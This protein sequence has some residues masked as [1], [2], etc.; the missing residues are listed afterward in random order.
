[1]AIDAIDEVQSLKDD[2]SKEIQPLKEDIAEIKQNV[3]E[4]NKAVNDLAVVVAGNYVKRDEFEDAL[5]KIDSL[6]K[7]NRDE[8]KTITGWIIAL[9]LSIFS[10]IGYIIMKGGR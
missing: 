5:N 4:T 8:H 1:M 10:T 9:V 7:E 3:K 2:F 6:L